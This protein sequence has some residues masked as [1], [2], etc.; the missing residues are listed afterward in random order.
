MSRNVGKHIHA[1]RKKTGLADF[2]A[3]DT[4][5]ETV[6]HRTIEKFNVGLF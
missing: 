5:F 1:Y 6:L 4:I 2:K 3:M